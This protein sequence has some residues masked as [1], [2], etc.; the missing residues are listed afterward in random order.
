[1]DKISV[2]NIAD[3]IGGKLVGDDI[4][5]NRITTDS[6]EAFEGTAF[7]GIKGEKVDGNT[8]QS[9][10][11]IISQIEHTQIKILPRHIKNCRKDQ[12]EHPLQHQHHSAD[13]QSCSVVAKEQNHPENKTH[14]A[15]RKQW[16]G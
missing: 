5:I 2:K 8:L 9:R 3:F 10:H 16:T 12:I 1:M 7:I 6:R 11:C 13:D 4:Y 15:Q 14:Q